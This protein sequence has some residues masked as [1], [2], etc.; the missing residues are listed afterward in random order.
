VSELAALKQADTL[1]PPLSP[2]LGAGQRGISNPTMI[3]FYSTSFQKDGNLITSVVGQKGQIV[4][5]GKAAVFF[6]AHRR[7]LRNAA[8]RPFFSN[9]ICR[10]V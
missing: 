8:D 10:M 4:V 2:M 3:I 7:S 5:P 6:G 1:S 9:Q